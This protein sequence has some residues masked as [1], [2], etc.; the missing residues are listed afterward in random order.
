MKNK[1]VTSEETLQR[2]WS[3][4]ELLRQE[5]DQAERDRTAEQVELSSAIVVAEAGLLSRLDRPRSEVVYRAGISFVAGA[6]PSAQLSTIAV[7][8]FSHSAAPEHQ[9]LILR[10][11]RLLLDHDA[12]SKLIG[13]T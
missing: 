9:Q 7:R 10:L 2:L 5:I 3:Q 12:A 13:Q 6:I 1:K 8:A 4:I 11:Q